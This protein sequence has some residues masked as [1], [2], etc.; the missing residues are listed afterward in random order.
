[1]KKRA[2]MKKP[3]VSGSSRTVTHDL[4]T[5]DRLLKAAEHLFAER[6]FKNVTVRDICR[7]ARANVAAVNYHFGDKL[8]LYRAVLRADMDAVRQASE[9]AREAGRGQPPDEQLRRYMMIWIRR[10]LTPGRETVHR[11]IQHEMS[12]PTPLLDEMVEQVV[13]P[14][15]EYL[16][17]VV[18]RMLGRDPT[19]PI[20]LRCVAST[21]AQLVSYLPNPVA[22]RLGFAFTS[23]PAQ[24]DEVARHI[25][26]FSVA[27][28]RAIAVQ[29]AQADRPAQRH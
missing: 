14:R 26:D 13:R 7:A 9:S 24:I 29:R 28:I 25:A 4:E 2:G 8:G 11:L 23:T 6:G 3:V 16:S 10:M 1:M 12:D 20:V 27:G 17:G 18:A 5:R 22:A 19:D 21:Q 15:L